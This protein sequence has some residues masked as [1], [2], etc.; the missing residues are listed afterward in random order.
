MH[1]LF[2]TLSDRTRL[3]IL[4]LLG[5]G[6]LCVCYFTALL[7]APQP[8]ISRHLAHLREAGLVTTRREGKWV[9]YSL[10]LPSDEGRSRVLRVVM[11]ELAREPEMQRDA[12]ALQRACCAPRLPAALSGA[13]RPALRS[14]ATS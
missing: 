10:A 3:R 6:E 8:T 4:N 14:P 5:Q 9:H 1:T 13:P 2:E 12:E 7:G 11:E